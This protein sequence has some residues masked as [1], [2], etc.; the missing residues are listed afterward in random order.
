VFPPRTTTVDLTGASS[1]ATHSNLAGSGSQGAVISRTTPR[2]NSAILPR[3]DSNRRQPSLY[4]ELREEQIRASEELAQRIAT[5]DQRQAA[6]SDRLLAA[7]LEEEESLRQRALAATDE[8]LAQELTTHEGQSMPGSLA[9]HRL[10]EELARAL[11]A[12]GRESD[13][14]RFPLTDE[15]YARA[16][17]EELYSGT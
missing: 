7:A 15:E 17:Q 16:L 14:S 10:D 12:E 4:D 9:Q 3:G 1:T 6:A 13:Q 2:T 5:E 11:E 8:L